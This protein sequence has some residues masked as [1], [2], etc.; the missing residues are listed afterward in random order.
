VREL[1]INVAKHARTNSATVAIQ[2][3]TGRL[4][5][6]VADPGIGFDILA[7]PGTSRR[8][9]G[10]ISLKERLSY[11]GGTF[12]LRTMPGSG[13]TVILTSPLLTQA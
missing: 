6:T 1:L 8:P 4:L 7:T 3:E 9:L 10:L 12:E 13:T 5:L 2:C 11:I